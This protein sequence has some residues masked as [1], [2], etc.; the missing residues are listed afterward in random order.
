MVSLR[1]SAYYIEH[2]TGEEHLVTSRGHS[3]SFVTAYCV[4]RT[5]VPA[6]ACLSAY[7]RERFS[8]NY[9]FIFTP[10]QSETENTVSPLQHVRTVQSSSK[11]G[12]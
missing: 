4:L 9:F 6:A 2:K 3:F 5:R 10:E 1:N 12:V 7:V 11:Q 8:N